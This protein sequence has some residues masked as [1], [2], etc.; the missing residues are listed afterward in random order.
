M[1]RARAIAF[2]LPQFHP[3]PENDA[4]WGAGFTEWTNVAK[5]RPLFRGHR[6][7][8]M[9]ADLGFYDLRLPEVRQA[10]ADLAERYGNVSLCFWHY[11]F[12]GSRRILE[13]PVQEMLD[14]GEPRNLSYCLGWANETWSGIWHG[15][16]DVVLLE[17]TYPGPEDER[18]H[19]E[20]LMRHFADDRYL[21]VAGRPL[22]YVFKP[23][24]LPEGWADRFRKSV[25]DAGLA[26]P[27]LVGECSDLLGRGPTIGDPRDQGLDA[28]AYVRLPARTG[29]MNVLRMR[30][31]RKLGG[32]E[33]Y[34]YATE[35]FALPGSLPST[36]TKA[37]SDGVLQPTVYPNWDNT[38]RSGPGGLVLQGASPALFTNHV[39]AAVASIRDRPKEQRLLWV[40]SW[41]EWAEGNH[42]E[43][44]AVH[45]HAWLEA[46]AAGLQAP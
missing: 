23:A 45:G 1:Q 4:W 34:P 32:P 9:P 38:P 15:A 42:L 43:P 31:R 16:R 46:L 8:L 6:Q 26:E 11:W 17:Q 20:L 37:W 2:H 10:Q 19:A 24:L 5:A 29:P 12:G 13:R 33:V 3:V 30:A 7:P 14:L 36:L 27:Y 25:T 21:T 41:N 18:V 22:L 39:R 40:K 44:D 28:A 35:P